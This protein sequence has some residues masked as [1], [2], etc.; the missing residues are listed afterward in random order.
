[1]RTEAMVH[2]SRG[3]GLFG[4]H[5]APVYRMQ[6]APSQTAAEHVSGR[7]PVPKN[8]FLRMLS[9]VFTRAYKARADAPAGGKEPLRRTAPHKQARARGR[10]PMASIAV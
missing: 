1:M 2:D 4:H 9:K 8:G 6:P 5:V 7:G 10:S 3:Q